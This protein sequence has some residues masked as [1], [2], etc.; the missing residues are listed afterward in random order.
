[1]ILIDP[2]SRL[3][4]VHT[5]VRP[6]ATDATAD[7]ELLRLWNALVDQQGDQRRSDG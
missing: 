7:A 1:V 6:T 5:A 2:Q 4:L 3:V